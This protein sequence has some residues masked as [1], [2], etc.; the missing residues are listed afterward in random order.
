MGCLGLLG[1]DLFILCGQLHDAA[2][3]EPTPPLLYGIH[4]KPAKAN[5]K[6][7][8]KI[9]VP[10]LCDASHPSLFPS[11]PPVWHPEVS[12]NVRKLGPGWRGPGGR[13]RDLLTGPSFCDP[14]ILASSFTLSLC[15]PVLLSLPVSWHVMFLLAPRATER[16]RTCREDSPILKDREGLAPH[17]R[18]GRWPSH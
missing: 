3:P 16:S 6:G 17:F 15:F 8:A 18:P 7:R 11:S 4:R 1:K 14:Q 12:E 2:L 9:Q 10:S 13:L 5:D